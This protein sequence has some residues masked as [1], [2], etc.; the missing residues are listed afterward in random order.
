MVSIS[1]LRKD[2]LFDLAVSAG[3]EESK[4]TA[5]RKELIEFL[6]ENSDLVD[7]NKVNRGQKINSN[8]PTITSSG[9]TVEVDYETD[10]SEFKAID[11]IISSVMD[12]T[13]ELYGNDHHAGRGQFSEVAS[14]IIGA[15]DSPDEMSFE[16]IL[17]YARSG[18]RMK[19]NVICFRSVMAT[20]RDYPR[21][22]SSAIQC[23]ILDELNSLARE[24]KKKKMKVLKEFQS[25]NQRERDDER[26]FESIPS[27]ST[28]E[29][30]SEESEDIDED[31]HGNG[32]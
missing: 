4:E 2:E 20:M 18:E 7:P 15:C 3:F 19:F 22:Y 23:A 21:G 25:I 1:R 31:Q 27:E 26:G 29:E 16:T 28:N 24:T 12:R 9:S 8:E 14:L 13:A 6:R 30:D 32:D 10:F 11:S 5:E 17:T